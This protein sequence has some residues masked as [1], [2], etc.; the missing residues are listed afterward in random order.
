MDTEVPLELETLY[1]PIADEMAELAG[2]LE[3]EFFAEEPFLRE[4]FSQVARFHGKQLRPALLFLASKLEGGEATRDHVKVAAVIEL[5]HTATLVH[6]DLLDDA[7]LR[8]RVETVHR[9][10]GDRVAVLLGD[11]IYSRAFHLS[12]QVPG[13]AALLSDATHT[14]CEGELLQMGERFRAID[15]AR[16]FE[17]IEKK[18]ATL[19]AAACEIGGRLAGFD[20]RKCRR[21]REFGRELG[22]AFQI[23]DD[24]L[25]YLGDERVVGKSLGSDLRQ[26]KVTLPLIILLGAVEDGE[27]GR[28]ARLLSA[29]LSAEDADRIRSRVVEE[30]A[31]EESLARAAE[32]AKKAR[33]LLAS[34]FDGNGGAGSV[35]EKLELVA[36]YVVRRKS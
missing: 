18:T 20:A 26:G 12:T 28:L 35:R 36:E 25:D 3:R 14:I 13:M 5:I 22:K 4:L 1:A 10:W 29:P 9:R 31:A 8:R 15:E 24:C 7:V 23:V 27:K 19:Y 17:I 33:K 32:F 30:G 6:D 11:Y 16:Y 34:A 2:F 21:L